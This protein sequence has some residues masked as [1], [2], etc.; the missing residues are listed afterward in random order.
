MA[1]IAVAELTG[2]VKITQKMK[3][4]PSGS[5]HIN[6]ALLKVHPKDN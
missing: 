2:P 1:G 6:L 3:I 5:S 4:L